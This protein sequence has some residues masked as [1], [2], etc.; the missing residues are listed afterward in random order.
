MFIPLVEGKLDFWRVSKLFKPNTYFI[1]KN[2][3][4]FLHQFVKVGIETIY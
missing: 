1:Y 3:K 2:E 4:I